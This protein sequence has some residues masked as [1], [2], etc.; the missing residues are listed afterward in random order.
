MR[1]K[2][3]KGQLFINGKWV[4]AKSNF[5]QVT[6][7]TGKPIGVAGE[8]NREEVELAVNAA[9]NALEMW[10]NLPIS[11][12]VDIVKKAADILIEMYGNEGEKTEL[13]SLISDEVGKRLPEADIEVI[14]SSDMISY[15]TE[16]AE[17]LLKPRELGLNTELW[18]TKKSIVEYEPV[19]VVGVIK[20][21]NYPLELPIW[22]LAPALISGNTIVFKPSEH[23]SFIG[24]EIGKIFEK[25][26]LPKGVL[27]IVTGKG[28]TGRFIVE[29]E[30]VNMIDFTGSVETGKKIAIKCAASLKKYNLELGGND[31]AIVCKDADIELTSNG[32]VWGAF[33]NS[34]QVCVGIKRAYIDTSIEKEIVNNV[35]SKTNKLIQGQDY[36]P[37]ISEQ[38]LEEIEVFVNDAVNKGAKILTGGK[39]IVNNSGFYY[40]P[41]VLIDV[42]PNMRI[43]QEE[44]FGP[45]LPLVF[46][47]N[48]DEAINFSNEGIYGLGASIWTS[49]RNN[50]LE[51]ARKVKAGMVWI[52]DVNVAFP[53]APWGGTK[54]SG[55]GIAL[56]DQAIYEY[57]K[58]K[59]ISIEK[60]DEKKRVWWYPYS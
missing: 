45:L 47:K 44:C 39:R 8:A 6:P 29:D 41:T 28:D 18:P 53:E 48:D 2:V 1:N 15:F 50:G 31:P 30:R 25:A 23:S 36:G 11:S 42:T 33:C 43:M 40:L 35:L 32:L 55:I 38:Q 60:S 46:V 34:G 20:A 14:E 26:G 12:R 21:W 58:F 56:S 5:D 10:A 13:K 22:T 27:N 37:V 7:N 19:G 9:S 59:H 16:N 17:N 24:I 52:N 57:V 54:S 51:I 49:D 4:D 3:K